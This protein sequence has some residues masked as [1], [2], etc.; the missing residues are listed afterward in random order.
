MQT[1]SIVTNNKY[2]C[3]VVIYSR[4]ANFVF[5]GRRGQFLHN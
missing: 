4:I 3:Y 5:L 2:D 1:I